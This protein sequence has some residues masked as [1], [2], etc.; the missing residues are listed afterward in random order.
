MKGTPYTGIIDDG[1]T[2]PPIVENPVR[3]PVRVTEPTNPVAVIPNVFSTINTPPIIP[4]AVIPGSELV[5][6]PAT[7]TIPTKATI[8]TLSTETPPILPIRTVTTLT[9]TIPVLPT[10]TPIEKNALW[11][12]IGIGLM[13]LI[14]LSND[15]D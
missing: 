10:P 3:I 8:K 2:P 5:M 9:E 11:G 7:A 15:K 14:A 4:V 12:I 1:S 13:I 6:P